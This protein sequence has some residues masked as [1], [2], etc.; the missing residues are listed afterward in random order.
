[1]NSYFQHQSSIMLIE[2][3]KKQLLEEKESRQVEMAIMENKIEKLNEAMKKMSMKLED[4]SK[5]WKTEILELKKIL[6]RIEQ[7]LD[8]ESYEV[9][10]E[11]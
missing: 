5:D 9:C 11:N 3:L 4:S 1:M 7:K 6:S 10:H 8:D 2:F